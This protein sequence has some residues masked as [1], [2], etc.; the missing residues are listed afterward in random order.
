M[1]QLVWGR[2]DSRVQED[3]AWLRLDLLQFSKVF[4]KIL[5]LL[6][7]T[8]YKLHD[9]SDLKWGHFGWNLQWHEGKSVCG[10]EAKQNKL[11]RSIRSIPIRYL[12]VS[13]FSIGKKD[14][15]LSQHRPSLLFGNRIQCRYVSE[16]L[17]TFQM[18]QWAVHD[19]MCFFEITY[20][21][22]TTMTD[23]QFARIV[24]WEHSLVM[25]AGS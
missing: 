10:S 25:T 20:N 14:K 8:L 22:W 24:E 6:W 4:R 21:C 1:Q 2:P 23:M 5:Y 17:H 18:T 11:T 9:N 13:L 7:L 3:D 16:M 15:T 12:L 19:Y